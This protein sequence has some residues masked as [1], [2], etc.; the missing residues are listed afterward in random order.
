MNNDN[1]IIENLSS[2][3]IESIL[4]LLKFLADHDNKVSI[5]YSGMYP[6]KPFEET[7]AEIS[8]KVE[9]GYS[10]VDVIRN[11]GKV[12]GFCQYTIKDN[13]GE[14]NYLVVLPECKGQGYGKLLIEKALKYFETQQVNNITLGTVYGNDNTVIFYEKYGFKIEA[15][16]MSKNMDLE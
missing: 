11:E 5:Y 1:V 6:T 15:L 7:I 16:I 13:I 8:K 4:P 10:K 3:E 12:I 14:L 2:T 9:K